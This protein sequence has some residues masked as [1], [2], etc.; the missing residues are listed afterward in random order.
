MRPMIRFAAALLLACTAVPAP[1]GP[2]GSPPAPSSPRAQLNASLERL[3]KT[4]DDAGLRS[5]IITLALKLKAKPALS[6]R[7]HELL[8]QGAYAFKNA[9]SVGDFKEAVAA[10]QKAALEAPWAADI[11]YNM[12]VA[13]EK[14]GQYDGAISSLQYYLLASPHAADRDAVLERIGGLKYAAA[15]AASVDKPAAPRTDEDL[16]ASLD[17]A[18]FVRNWHHV[19][20]NQNGI[21]RYKVV[22]KTIVTSNEFIS[23]N[24]KNG[25]DGPHQEIFAGQTCVSDPVPLNGLRFPCDADD[26]C[27]IAAD[28]QHVVYHDRA[29]TKYFP[30]Q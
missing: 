6:D 26:Y 16:V 20:W 5:E 19:R 10:Y 15:K 13:Q 27:E 7:A 9:K 1:A 29:E 25:C 21:I 30:K 24:G 2:A 3:R 23:G 22:G 17:G 12:A 11:Y 18:V 14:A 8:G 4:P 28:G